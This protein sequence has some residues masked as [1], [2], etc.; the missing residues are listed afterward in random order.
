MIIGDSR[1]SSHDVPV[2]PSEFIKIQLSMKIFHLM[3]SIQEYQ[4]DN[5]MK[6]IHVEFFS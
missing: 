5:Q 2:S 3:Y 4:S 1:L 6:I